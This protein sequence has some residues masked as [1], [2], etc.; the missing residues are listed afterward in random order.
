METHTLDQRR[1]FIHA[2]ESGQW[3]MSELCAR[4]GVSRPTGYKWLTRYRAGGLAALA[5]RSHAPQHCPHRLDGE[6]EALIVAV[7]RQFGWGAKKLV[8]VLRRRYPT[9]A[10]PARSTINDVLARHQLLRRQRRRR[11]WTHPGGAPLA[12]TRP[13]QVW[14][15]DFKGQFKTGDG[16][17]CY[18]LTVTDHYSRALL[19][20]QALPSIRGAAV[21]PIFRTLFRTVGLPDAIRTDNGSPFASP[22]IHGLSALNVWWMQLGIV[23]QRIAP[24]RPQQN[25]TH[26]RMHRELKRET[27]RP[28]A[29]TRGAQQR[30]FEAFRHRYNEERPHEALDHATPASRWHPAPRPYPE[31]RVAPEYPRHMDVRRISS[32]GTFSWAGRPFFLTETLH[33]EDIGLEEIHDGVWNIVYYRTLLGRIDVR[34]GQLTGV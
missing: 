18:P 25:G 4:F 23:H 5:D 11:P 1:K 32:G 6:R 29:A 30:R 7:R 21:Q 15:A 12:T 14:P 13:N 24:G 26:E 20:C 34:S 28:A 33:G 8:Q 22:A 16:R 2:L 3:S 9:C 17:Y 31:H 19:V 10:W 27:T